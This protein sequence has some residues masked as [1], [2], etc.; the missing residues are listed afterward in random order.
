LVALDARVVLHK[1]DAQEDRLPTLAIRPYPI[2]YCAPWK[3]KN[4]QSVMIR[5][6]RPEDEPLIQNFHES[7]SE[8]TVYLRYFQ[9]LKLSQRAAHDRLVRICFNDY[10]R[11]IALVVE[12]KEGRTAKREILA[13]AR[14]AKQRNVEE[15]EF[16][17]VV[18]DK[19]QK[20]GLGTELVRRLIQ[21]ARDEKLS[22]LKADMLPENVGMLQ[23]CK[24]LGFKFEHKAGDPLVKAALDL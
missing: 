19:S 15:A 13:V 6:I 3:L 18:T 24:E 9:P 10:D 21:I 22:R 11:E 2:Q 1:P 5:P 4:G 23:L 20:Q 7:L 8:Q 14:M 17:V 16:A 12:R